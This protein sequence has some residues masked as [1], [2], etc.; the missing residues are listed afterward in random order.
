[1]N[2]RLEVFISSA[3]DELSFERETACEVLR[4]FASEPGLFELFPAMSISPRAACLQEVRDCDVFVLIIYRSY[5]EPTF[6]EYYEAVERNK[7][8]IVLL[9]D[10]DVPREEKV[11]EFLQG[12]REPH[13]NE[14]RFLF[15]TYRTLADF[16]TA[17][18]EALARELTRLLRSPMCTMTRERMYDLGT[19]IVRSSQRRL[20]IVQRTPSLFFG[21]RPYDSDQK[22]VWEREFLAHLEAWV[23]EA[24]AQD[25]HRHLV[26]AYLPRDARQHF[27][28]CKAGPREAIAKRVREVL[29]RYK[30]VQSDTGQ[31]L[32]FVA[33]ETTISGPFA[34]G[35]D[36]VGF[37]L[38]G[39]QGAVCL[40]QE[41]RRIADLIFEM[42][43]G[44]TFPRST[45]E[46]MV[47]ELLSEPASAQ[48][49]R[50]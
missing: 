17:F 15:K 2:T 31:R 22:W 18:R 33:L 25:S 42:L 10:T 11:T 14:A 47:E 35:D 20:A 26:Y 13:G 1:M 43:L 4:E 37:W 19:E 16:R 34:V 28:E 23:E 48:G 8:I 21:A 36:R 12:L 45:A 39:D 38:L 29:P 30:Q 6:E 41:N 5:S 40:Y 44:Q 49:R 32:R 27:L 7:P 46:E 3:M 50:Q 9:R 24:G